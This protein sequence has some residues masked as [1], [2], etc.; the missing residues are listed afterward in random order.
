M[1]DVELTVLVVS[2][3]NFKNLCD[4]PLD[5]V[6]KLYQILNKRYSV[7]IKI[8]T[9]SGKYGLSA[10]DQNIETLEVEDRNKTLFTQTVENHAS[11][12]DELQ[13]VSLNTITDP[14]IE[15]VAETLSNLQ[16][17]ITRYSYK[18]KAS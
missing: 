8:I 9:V 7:P 1:S 16:K 11:L 18:R 14:F 12:F 5:Y 13:I 6:N 4:N 2:D 17:N 15:G 3:S 10:I